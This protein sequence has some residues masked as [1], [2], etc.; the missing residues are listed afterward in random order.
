MGAAL[1]R[2]VAAAAA[3]APDQPAWAKP[4]CCRYRIEVFGQPRAPW[5]DS[6]AEAMDDAIRL[7]L[8]N[9]DESRQEHYLAVPVDMRV[10]YPGAR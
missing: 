6:A 1:W 10:R 9:W 8:A 3:P 5:R 7:E 2:G 4:A